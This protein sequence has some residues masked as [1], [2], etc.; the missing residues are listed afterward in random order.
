VH[1]ILKGLLIPADGFRAAFARKLTFEFVLIEEIAEFT[2]HDAILTNGG[3]SLKNEQQAESSM[4]FILSTPFNTAYDTLVSCI[5]YIGH[6]TFRNQHLPFGIKE[7]DRYGGMHILG[8]TG[9]GKSTL[10]Y[11]LAQQDI[12]NG[13]G[14]ALIDPHSDLAARI[15]SSIPTHRA[16]DVIYLNAPD[17]HSI[18]FNPLH[19]PPGAN[20][21]LHASEV[22]SAMKKVWQDSWGVRLEYILR[23][24]ILTL[25]HTPGST[26]LDIQPL[27]LDKEYREG[28]LA[29]IADPAITSF[30]EREFDRYSPSVRHEVISSILNKSGVF[31]ADDTLRTILGNKD[32]ISLLDIIETGKI[33]I[34]NAS[35][36][37]IGEQACMLLGALLI[38]SIQSVIMNRA[39]LTLSDR[40]G[41]FLYVDEVQHFLSPSCAQLLSEG[42]KFALGVIFAHQYLDQLTDEIRDAL[43]GN[44]GTLI[45]FRLGTTDAATYAKEFYPIFS[46]DDF[47]NLPRFH[48]CI[49]LLIDGMGSRGFSGAL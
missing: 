23:Y 30:W 18:G 12:E 33:L 3:V 14:L 11:N 38:A 1:E 27:L 32:S 47:I 35:K 25:L 49:K 29:G 19:I 8:K 9:T 17:P 5:T 26:L 46:L 34:V 31:L 40:K 36:G 28:M 13:N 4:L 6:T 37:L 48:F 44:V 20:I 2:F 16:N 24:C 10:L 42:R 15:I 43:I 22:V 7:V 21:H 39:R 45:A 41:F